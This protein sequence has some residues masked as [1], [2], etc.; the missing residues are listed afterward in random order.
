MNKTLRVTVTDVK[1]VTTKLVYEM[2]VAPEDLPEG[3][4]NHFEAEA[5]MRAIH[6]AMT[7]PIEEQEE[8]EEQIAPYV[9]MIEDDTGEN[10]YMLGGVEENKS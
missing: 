3:G 6:E 5:L 2:E 10:L 4:F 8:E 1:V 9:E 7:D